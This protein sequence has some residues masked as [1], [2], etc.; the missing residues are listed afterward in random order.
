MATTTAATTVRTVRETITVPLNEIKVGK[1]PV[2]FYD[3]P[4]ASVAA[5]AAKI[6]SQGLIQ[7][8]G[9]A[10]VN[11]GFE[12]RHGYRRKAAL[13][14]IAAQDKTPKMPV[15]CT[16]VADDE[17]KFEVAAHENLQQKSLTTMEFALLCAETRKRYDW[18][19]E[20]N[21]MKVAKF[22]GV[23][24]TQVTQH[25]KLLLLSKAEQRQVH[26][27]A[28]TAQAAFDLASIDPAL[29]ESI[30]KRAAEIEAEELKQKQQ[31]AAEKAKKAEA[32]KATATKRL[33]RA[34]KAKAAASGADEIAAAK[35]AAAEAETAA[36]EATK[37]AAAAKAA[38]KRTVATAEK[39]PKKVRAKSVRRA[40]SEA[41]VTVTKSTMT[42][43]D[44]LRVVD[45]LG[46]DHM[47]KRART[48]ADAY[49][50]WYNTRITGK[51][52]AEICRTEV[53]K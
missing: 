46:A 29:R 20:S 41:G 23:S 8:L 45:I 37:E 7:P 22:L 1:N 24:K 38:E 31:A 40:A 50:R 19:G 36:K 30:V 4:K 53:F 12:L 16:L 15:L 13:D 42:M 18:Q 25:E 17:D 35:E 5:F 33:A 43:R 27:G 10:S 52:F 49:M 9:V 32:K 34:K 11:G 26:T 44:W 6:R 14:M 51:K 3:E 47:P 21:T 28:I 39:P 48:F 2:R